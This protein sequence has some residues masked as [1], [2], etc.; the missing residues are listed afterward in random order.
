MASLDFGDYQ[1]TV[2]NAIPMCIAGG[3]IVG[4]SI[5]VLIADVKENPEKRVYT[6]PFWYAAF[7]SVAGF[8]SVGCWYELALTQQP[9]HVRA[10]VNAFF[11]GM[12]IMTQFWDGFFAARMYYTSFTMPIRLMLVSLMYVV[13]TFAWL[14]PMFLGD[15]QSPLNTVVDYETIALY[16]IIF[17]SISFTANL[18]SKAFKDNGIMACIVN[19]KWYQ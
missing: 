15:W 13:G 19:V 12:S 10:G 3:A 18:V 5:S 6:L 16:G 11:L 4:C 7:T 8:I 2:I 14:A 17:F 9:S 1:D